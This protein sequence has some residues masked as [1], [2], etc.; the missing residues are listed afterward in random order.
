MPDVTDEIDEMV[1]AAAKAHEGLAGADY[2]DGLS[3]RVLARLESR[4]DEVSMMSDTTKDADKGE[5]LAGE[6]RASASGAP[7]PSDDSGLHDMKALAH[8]AK[9]R[10]RRTTSQHD[11]YDDSLVTSSTSG[12][13][14][15][16]LPVQAQVVALPDLPRTAA[17]TDIEARAEAAEA[18]G[19]TPIHAATAKRGKAI[20]FIGGG[21]LAAAAVVAII[22]G[23]GGSKQDAVR[24][25][26][27]AAGAPAQGTAGA[28]AAQGPGATGEMTPPAAVAAGTGAPGPAAGETAAKPAGAGD[29][30]PDG[31]TVAADKPLAADRGGGTGDR[32]EP[33]TDKGAGGSKAETGKP[34]ATA[35]G[36]AA[37]AGAASA[38]KGGADK[39]TAAGDKGVKAPGGGG[40]GAAAGGG[41]QSI[42]DLLNQASGG[43]Q[44]PSEG[45]GGGGGAVKPEKTALDG[46]DI[47]AGMSS[48]AGKA[49]GCFDQHG[50]AGHVKIKA[51]VDPSGKVLKADATGDFAGTPTGGCVA[52]AVKTASF[53]TWTGAPM[54][55]SYGFTLVE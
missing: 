18:A 2:F 41:D 29:S 38:R 24:D 30:P 46:K 19:V 10:I 44:K 33:R 17:A 36:G 5:G 52:A 50:V 32:R 11:A 40:G 22:V 20:W 6:G 45:G 34:D 9:L 12:L 43:A 1:R 16:A 25:Q 4:Q 51:T 47:K 55:V 49:Q 8:T 13:R 3:A 21:V 35:T 37:G 39:A 28:P 15:V 53:A 31:T 23:G 54:T 27:V 7:G 42:E 14:A 26:Q 48:V